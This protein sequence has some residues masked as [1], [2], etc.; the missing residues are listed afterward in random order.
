MSSA[1]NAGHNAL[2]ATLPSLDHKRMLR[3]LKPVSLS[4]GEILYEPG[5]SMGCVYFP[6]AALISLLTIVDDDLA[7]EVG[8]VG[9][10]GMLGIP[11]VFGVKRSS[12][13]ALVQGAGLALA[14]PT[15]V[16]LRELKR[17]LPLRGELLGFAH[18]LMLQHG[19]SAACNR[20]HPVTARLARWLLMTRDRVGSNEFR[21]THEFLADMLG[22]RRAGVTNAASG[23]QR[24]KVI[25]N[26]RGRIRILNE[27]ELEAAACS[28]YEVVRGIYR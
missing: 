18:E 11:L 4:F 22:V 5:Q 15:S 8:M 24:R 23:L 28:C 12:V 21:L 1:Q 20:F 13:R 6:V 9:R 25:E 16:F 3:H 2:L 26:K 17:S 7:L 19:Q 14:M 10:E 27:G